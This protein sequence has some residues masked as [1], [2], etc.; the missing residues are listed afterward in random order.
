MSLL[1]TQ[2]D[3]LPNV[4]VVLC[5]SLNDVRGGLGE[6]TLI[7]RLE[8]PGLSKNQ[9]KLSTT[10]RRWT[11]LGVFGERNGRYT[12]TEEYRP[13]LKQ[14]EVISV[15]HIRAIARKAVFASENNKRFWEAEESKAADL[16]RSLAWLLA[17]DVYTLDWKTL[18]QLESDQL[19]LEQA[20]FA[21]NDTR[22]N[23]LKMWARFLGFLWTD[24]SEPAVDPTLAIR[25]I[26][27]DFLPK[28]EEIAVSKLVELF[29]NCLPVLD[30]GLYRRDVEAHLDQR[31]YL[32]PPEGTLSKSLSRALYRL[33]R[34]GAI[35]FVSKSDAGS[36]IKLTGP[37]AA[38]RTDTVT[39]VSRGAGA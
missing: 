36:G 15:P 13:V 3:G 28:G 10:L 17:Q 26:L 30:T 8:P 23:G 33:R 19:T 18:P 25:D 27:F 7:A 14:D 12:I 2:N 29:A 21:R 35:A 5:Q 34:E 9:A 24:G 38:R 32:Q 31:Y 20:R 11:E 4:F 6:E 22:L 39:H 1:N 37:D 16:T